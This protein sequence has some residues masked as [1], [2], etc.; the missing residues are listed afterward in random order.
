[1]YN[2]R[3]IIITGSPGTGKTTVATIIAKESDLTKSV[4]MHTDDFYHYLSKGAILPHLPES[5]EQNVV[6]T[7]AFLEAAKLMPVVDMM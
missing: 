2:G 6:V 1:M 7:E 5:H 4:H 3:I